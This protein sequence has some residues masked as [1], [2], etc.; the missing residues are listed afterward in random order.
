MHELFFVDRGAGPAIVFLDGWGQTHRAWD[1]V[2]ERLVDHHRVIRVDLRDHGQS[3]RA[4]EAYDFAA[5]ADDVAR[6]IDELGLPAPVLVGH[7]MGGMVVQQLLA[8]APNRYAGAVVLDAD[9]NAGLMRGLLGISAFFGGP[10]MRLLGARWLP[11]Y[12]AM[13]DLV[14][15]SWGWR[16]DNPDQIVG[17]RSDFVAN[18]DVPGLANSF[19]AYATRADLTSSLVDAPPTL[20]VRG[21]ADPIMSHGKMVALKSAFGR[22]KLVEIEGAGHM[23]PA[24]RPDD[25][26]QHIGRFVGIDP[27]D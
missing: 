8:D 11:A 16:R 9:L 2:A 12:A 3:P 18:N 22:A 21:T 1:A 10:L 25:V 15:Y 20:L 4:S 7:S 6:L 5:M 13:L 19:V 26:A 14:A 17:A 27:K 24:E 23:T